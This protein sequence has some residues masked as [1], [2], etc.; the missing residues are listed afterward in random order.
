MRCKSS[1]ADAQARCSRGLPLLPQPAERVLLAGSLCEAHRCCKLVTHSMTLS[2]LALGA[3]VGCML[4]LALFAQVFRCRQCSSCRG[5]DAVASQRCHR[6]S[7]ST[8]PAL[9]RGQCC[10]PRMSGQDYISSLTL[11]SARPTL[12]ADSRRVALVLAGSFGP[13]GTP[14]GELQGFLS[15]SRRSCVPFS[16]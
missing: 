16:P 1:A 6:Q 9:T 12:S 5:S 10:M 14:G 7:R 8:Y 3:L 15:R 13:D 2:R 4:I 11:G